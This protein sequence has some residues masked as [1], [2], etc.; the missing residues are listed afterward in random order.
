MLASVKKTR[1]DGE[2]PEMYPLRYIEDFSPAPQASSDG[3]SD[4]AAA[5]AFFITLL[6]RAAYRVRDFRGF[7][8]LP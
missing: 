6:R 5:R 2:K 3:R 8:G 4:F 1:G 7:A